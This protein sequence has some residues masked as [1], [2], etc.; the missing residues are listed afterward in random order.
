MSNSAQYVRGH[1][2]AFRMINWLLMIVMIAGI[3]NP[4][5]VALVQAQESYTLSLHD[6]LPI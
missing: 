5:A 4:T 1:L 6:A 2:S 3:L